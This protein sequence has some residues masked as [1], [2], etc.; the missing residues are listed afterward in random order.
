MKLL[1]RL[2]GDAADRGNWRDRAHRDLPGLR[3]LEG[4]T[5][6]RPRNR[7]FP[8]PASYFQGGSSRITDAA[9][10]FPLCKAETRLGM[11]GGRAAARNG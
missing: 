4:L 3:D 7:T 9:S 5:P 10:T 6:T 8:T 2:R 1:T 11:E